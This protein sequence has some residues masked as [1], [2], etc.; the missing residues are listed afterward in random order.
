MATNI[1]IM[2]PAYNE[3]S[4]LPSLLSKISTFKEDLHLPVTILVVNDGST[5]NTLNIA[6]QFNTDILDLQPNRGLATA[7]REGFKAA[8]SGMKDDDIII[9]MDADDSHNPSLIYRMFLQVLEGSDIVIASRYRDG[10]RILGLSS[11]RIFL[12]SIAGLLFRIFTP[13]KGVRDFTCGYRAYR[14]VFLK[15]MLNHYQDKFIEQKGFGCM[16]EILLKSRRFNP[17]IHELPILLRYDF[18]FSTSKMKVLKT[19]SQTLR[20]LL[21]SIVKSR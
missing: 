7:M 4:T 21:M 16:V 8:I 12:S 20:L 15:K 17:I 13:I 1:K 19:V 9:T 5:D 3:E 6:K 14:V 10:S 11:Y 18:K 2:L